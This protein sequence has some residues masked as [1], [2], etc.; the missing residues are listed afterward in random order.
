MADPAWWV[1]TEELFQ[2]RP[3]NPFSAMGVRTYKRRFL[4]EVNTR[5]VEGE[6]VSFSPFIP[7]P[8]DLYRDPDGTL[9][10]AFAVVVD[11][12]ANLKEPDDWG[13]WIVEV[14]YSTNFRAKEAGAPSV[15]GG[16]GGQ[17]NNPEQEPPDIN[18]ENETR[19]VAHEKDLDNKRYLT[20][21]G[22]PF[23][24]PPTTPVGNLVI[25]YGRN[26]LFFNKDQAEHYLYTVNDKLWNGYPAGT[27]WITQYTGKAVYKGPLIYARVNFRFR[28]LDRL[29]RAQGK[30]WQ[31]ELQNSGFMELV[32]GVVQNIVRP[33]TGRVNHAWPLD[34]NGRMIDPKKLKDGTAQPIWLKFRDLYATDFDV[35][36]VV[37]I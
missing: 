16:H 36:Q 14:D 10:D 25:T 7:R 2:D 11:I 34:Q 6:L 5:N 37:G 22:V 19:E 28:I 23:S 18:Y 21:A 15:D 30:T 26:E 20:T 12:R 35:L 24:P 1:R 27:V 29:S 9:R 17:H 33:G 8:Y 4:V 3:A 13:F 32:N 31:K